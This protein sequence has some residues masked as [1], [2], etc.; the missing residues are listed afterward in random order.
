MKRKIFIILTLLLAGLASYART[1]DAALSLYRK[2]NL[3]AV[4]KWFSGAELSRSGCL[5]LYSRDAFG[6]LKQEEQKNIVGTVI[7]DWSTCL[8][9]KLVAKQS[10]IEIYGPLGMSLWRCS[11]INT[12]SA[13]FVDERDFNSPMGPLAPLEEKRGPWFVYI[14]GQIYFNFNGMSNIDTATIGIGSSFNFRLGTFLYKNLID[15]ALTFNMGLA[16][17]T[18]DSGDFASSSTNS[19]GIIARVHLPIIK[20]LEY[21][22]GVQQLFGNGSGFSSVFGIGYRT[23]GGI[24]DLSVN[25]S[26]SLTGGYNMLF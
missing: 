19:Y 25:T 8:E 1:P 10:F 14:G 26:G 7:S 18:N 20:N 15:S 22:F 6:G 4:E 16:G 17:Q 9:T 2:E 3:P 24:I 21:T 5:R 12:D 11:N 23:P 13:E